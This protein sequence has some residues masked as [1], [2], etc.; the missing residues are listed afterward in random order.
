MLYL[1]CLFSCCYQY[2][3]EHNFDDISIR[4]IALVL[5]LTSLSCSIVELV[6][7]RNCYVAVLFG[8]PLVLCAYYFCDYTGLTSVTSGSIE[9]QLSL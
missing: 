1:E 2:F 7:Y 4:I 8:S 6:M 3:Y 5:M 9:T